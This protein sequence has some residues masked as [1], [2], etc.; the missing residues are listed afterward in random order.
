MLPLRPWLPSVLT[1]HMLPSLNHVSVWAL[2]G[3]PSSLPLPVF[4]WPPACFVALLSLRS[5]L[6]HHVL[7]SPSSLSAALLIPTVRL[8]TLSWCWLPIFLSYYPLLHAQRLALLSQSLSV[9]TV[10]RLPIASFVSFRNYMSVSLACVCFYPLNSLLGVA[11]LLVAHVP[12]LLHIGLD[13]AH[14]SEFSLEFKSFCYSFLK[15]PKP[16]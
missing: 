15:S 9:F 8:V 7:S 16:S 6:V 12:F 1:L 3:P 2:C 14:L 10:R 5:S 4:T 13:G 11:L